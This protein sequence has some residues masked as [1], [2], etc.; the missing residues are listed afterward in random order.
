[1]EA[2]RSVDAL[3]HLFSFVWLSKYS[4][5]PSVSSSPRLTPPPPRLTLAHPHTRHHYLP[6]PLRILPARSCLLL[7]WRHYTSS[8][9]PNS[10]W[11]N[12]ISSFPNGSSLPDRTLLRPLRTLRPI[13]PPLGGRHWTNQ[14]F[15]YPCWCC[16]YVKDG[17]IRCLFVSLKFGRCRC[18]C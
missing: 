2:C 7:I 17:Q 8:P 11:C 1:M 13:T 14:L 5:L 3:V 10:S 15:P 9:N 12:H 6:T 18:L 16:A 4:L